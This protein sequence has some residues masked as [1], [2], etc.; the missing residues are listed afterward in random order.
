MDFNFYL[1]RRKCLGTNFEI[2]LVKI[3]FQELSTLLRTFECEKLLSMRILKPSSSLV[4]S[5]ALEKKTVCLPLVV[6]ATIFQK[7]TLAMDLAVTSP[8]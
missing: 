6:S 7:H 4:V 2:I 1:I 8:V 3:I 5:F